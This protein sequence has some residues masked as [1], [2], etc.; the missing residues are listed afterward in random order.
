VIDPEK[1]KETVQQL[2]QKLKEIREAM[3]GTGQAL[4]EAIQEFR[5]ANP[6]PKR[7]SSP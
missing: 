4:R 6:R 7:T 1:A 3:G 2:G 5:E